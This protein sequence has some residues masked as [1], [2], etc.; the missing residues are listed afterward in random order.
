MRVPEFRFLEIDVYGE[1]T[2][3]RYAGQVEVKLYLTNTEKAD[4]ARKTSKLIVGIDLRHEMASTIQLIANLDAHIKTKPDWWEE[5]GMGLEDSEPIY[6][7]SK[8]LRE[9]QMLTAREK[10]GGKVGVPEEETKV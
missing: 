10:S 4:M 6:E 8:K 3:T 9:V 1:N 2:G 5:D 7:L